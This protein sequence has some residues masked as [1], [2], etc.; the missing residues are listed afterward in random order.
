MS[1]PK[2]Y[3]AVATGHATSLRYHLDQ[4]AQDRDVYVSVTKDIGLLADGAMEWFL[5]NAPEELERTGSLHIWTRVGLGGEQ[6]GE[7]RC[8]GF[9]YPIRLTRTVKPPERRSR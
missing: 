5:E 2:R 3:A 7:I 9:T 1:D 8:G 4:L 6:V